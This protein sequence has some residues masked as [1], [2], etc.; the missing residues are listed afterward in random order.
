MVY[1]LN[2]PEKFL[3]SKQFKP[4]RIRR[5]ITLLRGMTFA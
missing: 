4:S 1:E 3:W 5:K 2:T